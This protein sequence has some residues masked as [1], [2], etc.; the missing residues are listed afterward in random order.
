M[1]ETS[2][3]FNRILLSLEARA[4]EHMMRLAAELAELLH[5]ELVGLL[6][7]DKGLRDL[8]SIPFAREFR[9][10]GG[11]WRPVDPERLLQELELAASSAERL[12]LDM[13]RQSPMRRQFEIVRGLTTE[14]IASIS[15]AGD[16]IMIVEHPNPAERMTQQFLWLREAAFRSAAAV[17]LVPGHIARTTGPIV[18]VA[19]ALDD[20]S[21]DAASAI[22]AA[23]KE[24][25][26]I[27][28]ADGGAPDDRHIRRLAAGTSFTV[29]Q[30][31]L[32]RAA[33]SDPS[34]LAHAL[35]QIRE[36]LIVMSRGAFDP[37]IASAIAAARHVPVLLV[38]P[39]EILG[40][41]AASDIG[42]G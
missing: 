4:P 42:K 20:P 31:A 33:F 38:E 24:D 41:K 8:A 13:A 16:I 12:F 37:L 32:G 30:L 7:E 40:E 15:R 29:K 2:S 39:K 3:S 18:A 17:M 26:I 27:V 35:R 23:A 22:A 36:R 21:I 34:A 19:A 6:L 9:P 5:L 25:L 1:T 14:I 10:L 11:G 28:H